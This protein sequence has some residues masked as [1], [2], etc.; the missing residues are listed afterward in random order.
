MLIFRSTAWSRGIETLCIYSARVRERVCTTA[1]N[2]GPHHRSPAP[3]INWHFN[4]AIRM[5]HRPLI[6]LSLPADLPRAVRLIY[7]DARQTQAGEPPINCSGLGVT[8]LD[9][10]RRS[11]LQDP[12]AHCY[13]FERIIY[14]STTYS[15]RE[16]LY[17]ISS[18]KK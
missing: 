5:C 13:Q 12:R 8:S 15:F 18:D 11:Y 3:K 9:F 6:Y 17:M 2:R 4:L 10:N 1:D 14:L 7:F 16:S